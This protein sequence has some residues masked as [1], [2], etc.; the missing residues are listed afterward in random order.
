MCLFIACQ[1]GY[2]GPDCKL[3]CMC[4]NGETCDRFQGCLCSPRR[5][6]LQCEKEGKARSYCSQGHGQ[7]VWTKLGW[8]HSCPNS[9]RVSN[10][11]S[12]HPEVEK[13]IFQVLKDSFL[14][15]FYGTSY[16]LLFPFPIGISHVF[17]VT[18]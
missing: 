14:I 8:Y 9:P 17:F 15:L 1:P 16:W 6:G 7:H 4:T 12:F 3:R 5:Q 13:N 10:H 18:H 11:F 2:Y